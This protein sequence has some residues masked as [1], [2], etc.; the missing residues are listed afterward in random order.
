MFLS[1]S[2]S[3]MSNIVAQS[4]G[5]FSEEKL[6]GQNYLSWSQSIKMI[7]EGWHKFGFLK[8]KWTYAEKLFGIVPAMAY[9]TPGSRRL[10]EFMSF[11]LVSTLDCL[12]TNTGPETYTFPNGDPLVMTVKGTVGNQSL[13]MSIVKNSGILRSNL[14]SYMVVPSEG[15]VVLI[16][17][18]LINGMP[19]Y[20]LHLQTPLDCLKESYPS[21]RFISD[22][23]LRMFGCTAYPT[24]GKSMSKESNYVVPLESTCPTVVTLS[25]P[26]LHS[27]PTLVQDSGLL[28][29]QYDRSKTTVSENMV[30]KDSVDEVITDRED[31]IDEDEVPGLVQSTPSLVMCHEWKTAVMEETRA[32]EKNKTWD[33]CTLPKGHKIVGCKWVFALQYKANGTLKRH[34][35]SNRELGLTGLPLLSSLRDTIKDTPIT[36]YSQKTPRPGKLQYLIVYVDDIMLSEGDTVEIIPLKRKIGDEFN[37][38][39]LENLKYFLGI[40]VARSRE[41]TPCPRESDRIHVDKEKYQC[42]VGKFIYLSHTR[43]DISYANSE[44][45]KNNSGK[46]V[47][48]RKTDR[49]C[50]EAYTYSDWAG[51][52]VDRK[53]TRDI[54]PLCGAILLL[55]EIRSKEL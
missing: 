11:S 29:D 17:A 14:G 39:Y 13:S 7:L 48:F 49:R 53:S 33:L 18:H 45:F 43:P 28:R 27:T 36:L 8:E 37:I 52:I 23:P 6:N 10:I 26:N 50:N 35:A 19:S 44:E 54:A 5:Y 12:Q 47:R 42:L 38:K 40:E 1:L 32:L 4:A 15:N 21:T 16:V 34:K 41:G 3:Y 25:D 9:S 30:E 46:E 55:G 31:R 20:V 51:S 2:S 22:V 24:S